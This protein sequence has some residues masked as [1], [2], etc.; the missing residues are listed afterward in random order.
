MKGIKMVWTCGPGL[1]LD[2]R[3]RPS[4]IPS[5]NYMGRR[6][7]CL[8]LSLLGRLAVTSNYSKV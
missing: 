7:G 1:K 5:V 2:M 4:W 6:L 8:S 3:V